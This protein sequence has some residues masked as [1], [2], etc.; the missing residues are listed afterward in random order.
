M[1]KIKYCACSLKKIIINKIKVLAVCVAA[2]GFALA[3]PPCQS[4]PLVDTVK[5]TLRFQLVGVA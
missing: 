5:R 1:I 2:A 4:P 3:C